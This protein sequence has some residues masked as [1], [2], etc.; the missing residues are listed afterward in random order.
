[1]A[2]LKT[3]P[4]TSEVPVKVNGEYDFGAPISCTSLIVPNGGITFGSG[5]HMTSAGFDAKVYSE[6]GNT[7][8]FLFSGMMVESNA[9]IAA[10]SGFFYASLN[11][12]GSIIAN[13]KIKSESS[14]V[15]SSVD[16]FNVNAS[17]VRVTGSGG[18][19]V[20][21]GSYIEYIGSDRYYFSGDPST[22]NV[23]YKQIT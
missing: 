18:I 2:Q 9:G 10:S 6:D 4:F 19:A 5:M 16:T 21:G 13:G 14:G 12:D 8:K 7:H 3:I 11:R 23:Y 22:G 15:F 1:M 17:Q 20:L